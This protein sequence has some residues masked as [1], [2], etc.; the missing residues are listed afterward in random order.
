VRDV[1]RGTAPIPPPGVLTL[2]RQAGAVAVALTLE[3]KPTVTLVGP[4]ASA[5]ETP[6]VRV[7]SAAATACGPGC[8]RTGPLRAGVVVVRASGL[9]PVR[10]TVP[11]DPRPGASIV[12]RAAAAFRG[13]GSVSVAE[14][15][16]SGPS[17]PQRS[18]QRAEA[19]DR[20]SYRI[21]SGPQGIVVGTRRWDRPGPRAPWVRA[22]QRPPLRMP[23]PL[24]GPRSRNAFVVAAN[25][26]TWTVALF[27]P[28]L[29][30]W[31]EVRVD[32]RTN[33]PEGL[34]MTAPA[35]FMTDRYSRYGTP[36][37]VRP[38]S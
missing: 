25:G 31:F 16:A 30:A 13:A 3:Q 29:T 12:H 36:R 7:G 9:P 23:A 18:K 10:F 27:D 14:S 20:F 33:L 28:A 26:R 8:W 2:A 24:W 4:D 32:R 17:A 38:P 11:R 15:L 1:E 35:H 22:T 21:A 6:S 19:P 37:E 5:Y 34:R